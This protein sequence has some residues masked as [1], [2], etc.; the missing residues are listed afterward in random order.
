MPGDFMLDLDWPTCSLD[1]QKCP[2]YLARCD[3][4]DKRQNMMIA[5]KDWRIITN[6]RGKAELIIN[7]ILVM[8]DPGTVERT[9]ISKNDMIV[10]FSDGTRITWNKAFL[11]SI[12][13]VKCGR[14]WCDK[15]IDDS[16]REYI[17][18]GSC[19]FG[20]EKDVIWI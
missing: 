14:L 16:L 5:E 6:D 7:T 11:N 1:N 2:K 8:C 15:S 17:L 12:R 20:N 19:Y 9:I 13:G 18:Y 3:L 10:L 4:C